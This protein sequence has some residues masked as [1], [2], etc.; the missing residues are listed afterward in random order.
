MQVSIVLAKVLK[1]AL[2]IRKITVAHCQIFFG[3]CLRFGFA[4]DRFGEI[5]NGFVRVRNQCLISGL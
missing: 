3:L 1:L 4:R 5:S 2:R